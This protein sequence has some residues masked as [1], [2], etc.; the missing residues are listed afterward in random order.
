MKPVGTSQ[1]LQNK[2]MSYEQKLQN[3]AASKGSFLDM[4]G[5]GGSKPTEP[6]LQLSQQ[7]PVMKMATPSVMASVTTSKQAAPAKTNMIANLDEL[8]DLEL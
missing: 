3:E 4:I 7:E 2:P 8:E 1:A 5:G 6:K